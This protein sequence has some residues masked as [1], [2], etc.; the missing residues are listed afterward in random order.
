VIPITT[1]PASQAYSTP[2]KNT[3]G[4]RWSSNGRSAR[5]LSLV[6]DALT[7][8]QRTLD[9]AKPLPSRAT[10]TSHE[11]VQ[12]FTPMNGFSL[13]GWDLHA[14]EKPRAPIAQSVMLAYVSFRGGRGAAMLSGC[15]AVKLALL[16]CYPTLGSSLSFGRASLCW[17]A[18]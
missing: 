10:S 7:N 11:V 8:S 4:K 18:E 6:G 2:S 9:F 5:A 16:P 1:T 14:L 17:K 3:T 15:R 12:P 13:S